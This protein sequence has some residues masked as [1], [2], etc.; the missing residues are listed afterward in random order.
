MN[1]VTL[2]DRGPVPIGTVYC[3]GRNYVEHA[4][5]MGAAPEPVVFLKPASAV[6]SGGGILPWPRGSQL[7]HHEVE[8]VLL[9]G[10]GGTDLD[11]PA[12][13]AAIAGAAIGVDLTARDL[14]DTAKQKGQ[15]WAR[16]KGFPGSAPV[17]AFRPASTLS[18]TWAGLDLTLSVAGQLRQED[19]AAS[20]ILPPPAIVAQLS[21]WFVLAPGDL[22]FTGTPAGV[23]PVEPG[24][25]VVA[26]SIA[27]DLSVQFTLAAPQN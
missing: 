26:R 12:A 25:P 22:I 11:L 20:M 21:R 10:S 5:E 18:G 6:V 8:L 2:L 19:R 13:E 1:T 4:R 9:L 23:G 3:L 27:L 15:P 14:Q 17:S 24:Q 7:V 16:S